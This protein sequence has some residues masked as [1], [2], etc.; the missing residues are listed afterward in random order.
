MEKPRYTPELLQRLIK[1]VL[2]GTRPVIVTFTKENGEIRVMK[3]T[4]NLNMIP[5]DKH[6]HAL[7]PSKDLP[8]P[9]ATFARVFDLDLGEW[10]SFRWESVLEFSVV[11]DEQQR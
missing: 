1:A 10:R 11:Q 8:P 2:A 4:W 5:A 7:E 9:P 6:P 3:C